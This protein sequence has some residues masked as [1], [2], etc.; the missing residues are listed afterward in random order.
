MC[1]F[2]RIGHSA[3]TGA[4][5]LLLLGAPL[6][7]GAAEPAGTDIMDM[8][9]EELL[10]LD[11]QLNAM[12]ITGIH[13]THIGGEWMVGLQSMSMLMS[14]N[15][16]G[17]SRMSTADV[18]AQGYMVTPTKMSMQMHMLDIMYAPSDRVTL[19]FMLPYWRISMD[20]RTGLGVRFTT[21]SQGPGD[22]KLSTLYSAWQRDREERTDRL[23]VQIGA[24][25]PTGSTNAKDQTPMGR[26]TLPYP[27]QLGSGTVDF[28]PGLTYLGQTADWAWGSHLGGT[29]RFYENRQD[30]QLGNR[31]QLG[32]WASN[33]LTDWL[34]MSLRLDGQ[35]W[36]NIHGADSR[37][38]PAMV[39]T[40]DP[41]LRAGQRLDM[42]LGTNL[43]ALSGPLEGHRIQL[44]VGLPIY[45]H[46]DGPQ[47]ETDWRVSLSW[48]FT[49]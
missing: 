31:G 27:M 35:A 4:V 15:R 10:D 40:A 44:E 11:L 37:L 47:L 2:R 12:G 5:A 36:G 30:Y 3:G 26:T 21:D 17:S 18:L 22:I 41:D 1:A 34:S 28:R 39:P 9:L 49:F 48:N 29:F 20:H 42:L 19:M 8:E 13:H 23:V 6:V 46:L 14:G 16:D 45:Q 7:G 24:S 25:L 33:K 32:I 38:M 43:F